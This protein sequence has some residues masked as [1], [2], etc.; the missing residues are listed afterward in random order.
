MMRKVQVDKE[1]IEERFARLEEALEHKADRD[2]VEDCSNE[3]EQLREDVGDL[4]GQLADA[5]SR[6]DDLENADWT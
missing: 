4:E 6:I 5:E 3:L 1:Q 2:E